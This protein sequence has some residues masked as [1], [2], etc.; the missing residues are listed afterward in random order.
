[1]DGGGELNNGPQMCPSLDPVNITLR[2]KRD[3]TDVIK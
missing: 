1:M 2:G 3:C